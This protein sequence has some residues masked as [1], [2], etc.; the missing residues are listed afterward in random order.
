MK[1][2]DTHRVI[3]YPVITE[4]AIGTIETE[5]K[6]VFIVDRNATKANIQDAV[7][8]LYEVKVERVNVL[9]TSKGE[10]K[11]FVKLNP[12]YSAADVAIKLGI[13]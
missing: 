10:K 5:N 1:S 3:I 7:E 11:A 6:L 9:T 2:V 4:D 13:L 8:N 12:K